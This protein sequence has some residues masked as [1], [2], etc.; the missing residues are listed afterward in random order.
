MHMY[1]RMY[2]CYSSTCVAFIYTHMYVSTYPYV[3][4]R[5][6]I[7]Y[8]FHLPMYKCV[9]VHVCLCTYVRRYVQCVLYLAT[10]LRITSSH[11]I[12]ILACMCA[13]NDLV[14]KVYVECAREC[15]QYL[16]WVLEIKK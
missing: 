14:V 10:R 15:T 9:F 5:L 12:S 6:R 13:R 2:M 7:M 3:C 8:R 1:I 4:M 11:F 16:Q